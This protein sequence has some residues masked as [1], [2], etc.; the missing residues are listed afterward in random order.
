MFVVDVKVE[1]VEIV[2]FNNGQS[3]VPGW[4][5]NSWYKTKEDDN[6]V[7][8]GVSLIHCTV[9]LYIAEREFCSLSSREEQ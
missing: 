4:F 3:S 9:L 6:R 7:V 2:T 5:I 8:I 1:I